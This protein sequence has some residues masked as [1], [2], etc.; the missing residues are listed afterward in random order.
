M[1]SAFS[2]Q[3]SIYIHVENGQPDNNED[4]NSTRGNFE[5]LANFLCVEKGD[6]MAHKR[7][8]K[9]KNARVGKIRNYVRLEAPAGAVPF[10]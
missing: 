10:A 4:I 2:V 5:S 8:N 3:E 6:L 9:V 1:V 7:G